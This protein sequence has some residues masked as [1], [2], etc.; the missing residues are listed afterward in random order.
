MDPLPYTDNFTQSTIKVHAKSWSFRNDQ[1]K[2]GKWI[3]RAKEQIHTRPLLSRDHWIMW[4]FNIGDM[5][6]T[7]QLLDTPDTTYTE[8]V[9]KK[10]LA[11]SR[12]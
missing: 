3:F 10:G 5:W 2:A 4:L 11:A 9:I 12:C 8:L 7:P 6:N 1:I